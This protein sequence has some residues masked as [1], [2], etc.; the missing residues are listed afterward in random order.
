MMDTIS[1]ISEIEN[2]VIHVIKDTESFMNC[3]WIWEKHKN[4]EWFPYS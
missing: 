2:R 4:T 1:L 3:R